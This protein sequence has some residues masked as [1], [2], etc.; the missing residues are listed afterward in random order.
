MNA[1]CHQVVDRAR[2]LAAERFEAAFDDIVHDE[3]GF[4]VA[5]VPALRLSWSELAAAAGRKP[6]LEGQGPGDSYLARV[7]IDASVWS[8]FLVGAGVA[9]VTGS[10]FRMW[11]LLPPCVVMIAL[12]LFSES[13]TSAPQ[14]RIPPS[15]FGDGIRS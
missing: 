13:A 1:A 4:A 7:R 12:G 5:G 9:G 11:A 8:A 2:A 14:R 6:L 10:R 15:I 3:S